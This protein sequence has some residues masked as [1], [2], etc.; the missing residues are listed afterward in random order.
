MPTHV[1]C[2]KPFNLSIELTSPSMNW[3][4]VEGS[5]GLAA[6]AWPA[7][8]PAAA[9]SVDGDEGAAAVGADVVEG[10]GAHPS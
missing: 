8:V 3:D 5:G 2:L 4:W 9:P 1:M 7:A 6:L 10:V